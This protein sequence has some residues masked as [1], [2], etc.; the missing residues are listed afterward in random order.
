MCELIPSGLLFHIYVPT[1]I[2][3]LAFAFAILFSNFRNPINRNL[4]WIV[5]FCCYW[6]LIGFLSYTVTN[7]QLNLFLAR[8]E[9]LFALIA[10][11]LLYFSYYF[12]GREL[13]IK[14]KIILFL[15][16]LPL[17]IFAFTDYNSY[18]TDARTCETQ[19]GIFYYSYL[20]L[21]AIVYTFFAIRNLILMLRDKK[22]EQVVRQQV[23]IIISASA[24]AAIWFLGLS[25]LNNFALTRDYS[26]ADNVFLYAPIGVAIFVGML[27]FAFIKYKSLNIKVM[28]TEVM[29]VAL[30][31]ISAMQAAYTQQLINR[32][33]GVISVLLS[34]IFV[35]FLI[36]SIE[37]ERKRKE[38][39]QKMSVELDKANSKL[40]MAN[41]SKTE[42]ISIA[43]HQIRTPMTAIKGYTSMALE[44]SY[45][46]IEEELK[47]VLQKIFLSSDRV[48]TLVGD[49]LSVSKMES[50]R[51]EFKLKECDL[52]TICQEIFG[53]FEMHAQNAGLSLKFEASAGVLPMVLIDG[54]KMREVISNLIDNAI[55]YCP[56]GGIILKVERRG[57]LE[58][59]IVSDTGIGIPAEELPRLF[60]KFSRGKD[61]KRLTSAGSGIGLFV[62]KS[63]VEAN[64]GK[65]WAESDGKNKGSR[66]IIEL[67]IKQDPKIIK[68][69]S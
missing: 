9:A 45:G 12:S 2:A 66:F 31:G 36:R 41:N 62:G 42:F 4:F 6:N 1:F 50:G 30:L 13:G 49:M 19:G 52:Q 17:I 44:G 11:F 58:R 21:L 8:L 20:Y 22:I 26:W 48:V 27:A 18:L 37:N 59:V 55:K 14:K 39:L 23:K 63:I 33:L 53:I 35:V 56:Q 43:S 65:I 64:G 29:G 10:L 69:W 32:V 57:D 51:M 38:D 24:L 3:I 67:P 28:A 54:I 46:K 15:P 34:L 60:E 61:K 40:R 7:V 16:F 5:L 25:I 68:R 47:K